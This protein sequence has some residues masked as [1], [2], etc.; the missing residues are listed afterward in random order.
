MGSAC[1]RKIWCVL[2]VGHTEDCRP[3]FKAPTEEPKTW[4][5]L[6]EGARAQVREIMRRVI[7]EVAGEKK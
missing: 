7:Y 5:D 3:T 1:E 6:S 2:Q 4:A